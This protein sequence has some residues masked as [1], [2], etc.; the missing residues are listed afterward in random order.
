MVGVVKYQIA[1]GW[2]CSD[3]VTQRHSD[4]IVAYQ[5]DHLSWSQFVETGSTSSS[6]DPLSQSVWQ[7]DVENVVLGILPAGM[8]GCGNHTVGYLAFDFSVLPYL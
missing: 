7:G 2:I 3:N 4:E 8:T 1:R 6:P 5:T